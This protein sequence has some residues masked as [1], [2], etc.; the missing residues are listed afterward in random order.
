MKKYKIF[1][2]FEKEEKWLNDMSQAGYQL[3]KR[4]PFVG[5]FFKEDKKDMVIKMDYR[6]F[7]H[8]TDFKDYVT[9]FEDSGWKHITG[10]QYSGSQYFMKVDNEASVDIF[11]DQVSKAGR[12]KRLSDM[13]LLSFLIYI[14]IFIALLASDSIQLDELLHPKSLYYTEGLWDKTGFEFIGAFLFETPFALMRGFFWLLIPLLMVLYLFFAF[15]AS[16]LYQK[17]KNA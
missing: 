13:W 8:K 5:Y 14:P 3:I 15:K 7:N 1:F 6:V 9:L 17:N 10:S 11:S 16:R 12:Y 4:S 2:N